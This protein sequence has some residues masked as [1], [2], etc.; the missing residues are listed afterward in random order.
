MENSTLRTDVQTRV[1][2]Q[3]KSK[4]G[5]TLPAPVNEDIMKTFSAFPDVEL[6]A[7]VSYEN[8]GLSDVV[9]TSSER[10][11]SCHHNPEEIIKNLEKKYSE[12]SP[13]AVNMP[14]QLEVKVWAMDES[15]VFEFLQN[16]DIPAKTRLEVSEAW[17]RKPDPEAEYLKRLSDDSLSLE[18]KL[19]MMR[20]HDGE[21]DPA[22][23]EAKQ[24]ARLDKL[25]DESLGT[26][27]KLDIYFD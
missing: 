20:E 5:S 8:F 1:L 11:T 18:E 13:A 22:E 25:K 21:P 23:I 3:L 26:L 16:T 6:K 24:T 7:G 10:G 27:E 19:K 12:G 9:L 14:T 15:N 17:E 2:N 4:F